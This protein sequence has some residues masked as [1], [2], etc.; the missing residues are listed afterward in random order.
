MNASA[1]LG[2]LV[3]LQEVSAPAVAPVPLPIATLAPARA[4]TP[5]ALPVPV[6]VTPGDLTIR[7]VVDALSA[8]Q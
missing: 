6:P 1:R 4:P 3:F 8:I 7:V 2:P 5:V